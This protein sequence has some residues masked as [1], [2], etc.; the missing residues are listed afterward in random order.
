[1]TTHEAQTSLLVR[2]ALTAEPLHQLLNTHLHSD[3][4]G[5]NRILQSVYPG[6][7]TLVPAGCFDAA[8]RWD[9]SLLTFQATGQQCASFAV[10]AALRVGDTL[11]IGLRDWQIHAAPGHDPQAVLLFAPEDRILISADA[12]WESGFG[13]VFPELE[14]QHAFDEVGQTLDLIESLDPV[15]IIP[16]H[17]R[18]FSDLRGALERARSRLAA[19]IADPHRHAFYAAKVLLKFKLL[20]AQEM[21]WLAVENWARQTP[22]LGLIHD[23][24]FRQTPF[25]GWVRILLD[26]LKTSGAAREIDGQIMNIEPLR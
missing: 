21:P 6:I 26:A 2:D 15:L 20:E 22:Y 19:F 25:D 5:G 7:A 9:E 23:L 8:R 16:G 18:V 4:C 3:H 24:H 12:L 11:S 14:G 10:S 1:Y 17:G 13:V